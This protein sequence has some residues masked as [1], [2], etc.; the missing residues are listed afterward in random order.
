ML[1]EIP[2]STI[3]TAKD[4]YGTIH[5]IVDYRVGIFPFNVSKCDVTNMLLPHG[6]AEVSF[7][8][9]QPTKWSFSEHMILESYAKIDSN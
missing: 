7:Q 1:K 5:I 9:T 3:S 2:V 4:M 8:P 6:A